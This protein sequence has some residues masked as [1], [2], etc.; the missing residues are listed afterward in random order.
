[1]AG[2]GSGGSAA[3][4]G[5]ADLPAEFLL[6]LGALALVGTFVALQPY[7]S[8]AL[9]G[10]DSGEYYRLTADLVTT[11]HLPLASHYGGWGKAYPDFPGLFVIAGG[12]AQALG[13]SV[14]S[15][16][17]VVV[18]VVAAL[19]FLPLFLLFRRL[20][21][22]NGVALLAAAFAA[23]LMPRAF[24][25]AHPAPLALGDL[26]CVA[27]LWMFV[28]T[29]RDVRWFLPL[30][31]TTGGLIVTHHLSTF[32]FLLSAAG[33]LFLLEMWRPG[34]WSRRF[35]LRELLFVGAASVATLSFW[36]FGAHTFVH[37]VIDPG[38]GGSPL[39]GYVPLVASL[40]AGTA[41]AGALI[42]WRRGRFA[43]AR[44]WVRL[45]SARAWGRDALL[46]AVLVAAGI[47]A[48]LVIPVPG[49]SQLTTPAAIAWFTP[50][51]VVGVACAGSRRTPT[52]ARLGP[53]GVAWAGALGIGAA[54]TLVAA[55]AAQGTSIVEAIPAGRFVEYL[56]I[57]VGFMAAIGIARFAALAGDRAG[58]R[59]MIAVAVGAVVLVAAN[60]AIVYPPQ[61]DFGG[62]EE[63]YTAADSGLWMW[64]GLGLPP[65]ATVATDHRLSSAVFGFSG[66]AATWDSTP[67]LFTGSNW[68]EARAELA[69]APAPYVVRP[70]DYVIVD[71]VM[72]VGV[73]LNPSAAALPLS[74][75]AIG[76]FSGLPFVPVY[77]NGPDVVY[78]VDAA[79]MPASGG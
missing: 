67:A 33:G 53:W 52:V 55:Q 64:S 57:P 37:D 69:G 47:S 70:I 11:G 48:V 50:V 34:L 76:W 9:F 51:F 65:N 79:A 71:S 60:A 36:F 59:A 44:A 18:P 63:G 22:H 58:R 74:P 62:F 5:G 23:V 1:M 2:I 7:L 75:A 54:L 12:A 16:L 77:Q 21:P 40:L 8:Y 20:Y 6:W 29:R 28:E 14:Y 15:G 27:G 25:L 73:A 61:R 42:R 46:I 45:P 38:L 10:S 3:R 56:L 31:L 32:F 66:L 35:P 19:S 39:A 68:S 24:S 30:A 26:L 49:T 41:A 4:P 43:P 78:L 72:Y 13:I 17:T